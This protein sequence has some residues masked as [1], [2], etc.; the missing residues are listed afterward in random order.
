MRSLHG[1]LLQKPAAEHAAV[2]EAPPSR[3]AVSA[4]EAL[5]AAMEAAKG[6]TEADR[7]AW[8]LEHKRRWKGLR[9]RGSRING[10]FDDALYAQQL[11]AWGLHN[12]CR[13]VLNIRP[14]AST[15]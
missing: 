8:L 2:A 13:N 6:A 12:A 7:A 3:L 11:F 10:A 1:L 4:M 14:A 9:P 15:L 5:D